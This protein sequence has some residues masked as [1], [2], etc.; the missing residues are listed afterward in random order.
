MARPVSA[1][2]IYERIVYLME[3]TRRYRSFDLTR[4][5]DRVVDDS[6]NTEESRWRNLAD[7]DFFLFVKNLEIYAIF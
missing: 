2:R 3:V 4:I 5:K 1:P 6:A 7:R